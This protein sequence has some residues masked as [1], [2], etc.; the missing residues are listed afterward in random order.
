MPATEAKQTQVQRQC[1]TERPTA[2]LAI[3]QAGD[4]RT[5]KRLAH[6][7]MDAIR[8]YLGSRAGPPCPLPRPQALALHPRTLGKPQ[9][10]KH[11]KQQPSVGCWSYTPACWGSHSQDNN[12]N[13]NTTT[14]NNSNNIQR[15]AGLIPQHAGKATETTT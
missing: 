14:N 7:T 12:N 5:H 8:Q 3:Q 1:N 13:S 4:A 6:N 11:Q 9:W 10:S 2:G 15:G